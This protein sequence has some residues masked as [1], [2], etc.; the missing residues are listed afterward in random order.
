ME[1][2]Q[3]EKTR[4]WIEGL[5][6]AVS[7][8]KKENAE[9][10]KAHIDWRNKTV[11]DLKLQLD[12][13]ENTNAKIDFL[14]NVEKKY[15][16]LLSSARL[17]K[18]ALTVES[19]KV[20]FDEFIIPLKKF[21]AEKLA[22]EKSNRLASKKDKDKKNLRKENGRKFIWT[23]EKEIEPVADFMINNKFVDE[24]YRDSLIKF[25]TKGNTLTLIQWNEMVKVLTTIFF[26]L[27]DT[28]KLKCSDTF[29]AEKLHN[30]FYLKKSPLEKFSSVNSIRNNLKP[31]L[32]E[33]RISF[34]TDLGKVFLEYFKSF[35]VPM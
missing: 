14:F 16:D 21:Y 27:I 2:D 26:I 15:L 22:F 12:Q 17:K 23:D 19:Y 31:E 3:F 9:N 6:Y 20:V 8:L 5:N 18:E 4:K 29:L 35:K 30:C 10:R 1:E 34:D 25:L 13:I 11:N 28:K 24:Q 7:Q 33:K 32:H